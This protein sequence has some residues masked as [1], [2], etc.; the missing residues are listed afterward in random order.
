MNPYIKKFL[1]TVTCVVF[2]IVSVNLL[3]STEKS[4]RF[5][6]YLDDKEIGYHK[7][8]VSPVSD[9]THVRIE[10]RYNVDFL[11]FTAYKYEHSN[12]EI[13]L[14]DCLHYISSNTNDNGNH[15][16]V[17]A[18]KNDTAINIK[19]SESQETIDGC[20][21]S[22]AYWDPDFL[23]SKKLLNTQTGEIIPVTIQYISEENIKT[24]NGF[25]PGDRYKLVAND[26]TMDLWYSKQDEWL[27]LHSNL[28]NGSTLKYLIQ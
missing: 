20:I 11:F 25:I 28:S 19:T 18:E 22:F 26:F 16:Y 2:S 27:G 6:V 12:Y 9:E 4:W 24:R 10:A 7:V 13:W 15:Q 14:N 1:L 5:K 3:A 21:K 8:E 23:N 17:V